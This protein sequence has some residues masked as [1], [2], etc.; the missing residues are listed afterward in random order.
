MS[1]K[2]GAAGIHDSDTIRSPSISCF[3]LLVTSSLLSLCTASISPV[4]AEVLEAEDVED[5]DAGPEVVLG[6]VDG[7]VDLADDPD[8]EPAVDALAEGVPHV[9]RLVDRQQRPL[10]T[11][12]EGR[13]DGLEV[14]GHSH[15][16]RQTG[17]GELE[18]QAAETP[19]II[20]I[21]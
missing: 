11:D 17:T 12:S 1:S 21:S 19:S 20:P 4:G 7:R 13:G 18:D 15:G 3:V 14:G 5:A 10:R 6:S 2:P 9:H 8:E 16:D